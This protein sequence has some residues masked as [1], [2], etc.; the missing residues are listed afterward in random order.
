METIGDCYMVAGGLMKVDEET[1][2]VTV[3]S[4]DVDPLHAVRT[5]QF[6]KVGARALLAAYNAFLAVILQYVYVGARSE[7]VDSLH[8]A[9]TLQPAKVGY[10]TVSRTLCRVQLPWLKY[11]HRVPYGN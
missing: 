11:A 5:V 10:Q 6:A 8:A 1:G 3:R 2:A 9:R 4:E 7:G